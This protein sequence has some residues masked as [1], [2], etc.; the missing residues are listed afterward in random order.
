[1]LHPFAVNSATSSS[2]TSRNNLLLILN[3]DPRTCMSLQIYHTL[4]WKCLELVLVHQER[5]LK[6]W[7]LRLRG[8]RHKPASS[9]QSWSMQSSA[10]PIFKLQVWHWL[11]PLFSCLEWLKAVET[12]TGPHIV[13]HVVLCVVLTVEGFCRCGLGHLAQSISWAALGLVAVGLCILNV[14]LLSFWC[15]NI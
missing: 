1:M 8:M 12:I 6:P 14:F 11:L 2:C 4:L 9:C 15:H 3:G 7:T 5:V 10:L 13:F